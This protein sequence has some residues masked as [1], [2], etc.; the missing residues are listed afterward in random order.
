VMSYVV[1]QSDNGL[2]T[3]DIL[4]QH[5]NLEPELGTWIPGAEVYKEIQ[6][7]MRSEGCQSPFSMCLQYLM[8]TICALSHWPTIGKGVDGASWR[9]TGELKARS[10]H[11]STT[12][13]FHL[14][15]VFMTHHRIAVLMGKEL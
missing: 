12:A 8:Y 9:V 7:R 11:F 2:T 15:G 10:Q 5:L 6:G 3:I 4:K 1:H 14:P 13:R